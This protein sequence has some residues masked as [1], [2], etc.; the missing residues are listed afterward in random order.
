MEA[1]QVPPI[2][3]RLR[4]PLRAALRG[5]NALWPSDL[6]DEE[7]R[8][9]VEHGV[10]PLVY[11][12]QSLPN[13]RDAAIRA[14]AIEPL[15]AE[16]LRDVLRELAAR[17]IDVLITKGTALAYDVYAAPELRPR[18]DVDLLVAR[19][20][21]EAA[22]A[23]FRACGFTERLT[24]GDEH[25]VR[26][27]ALTRTD[28]H[29]VRHEYDLH[30]DVAN[31]P[32]FAS[33]LQFETVR[34]R[35]IA[36]PPLGEHARGLHHPDALLLACIH[37]VAHHH[38]SERLIWLVDIALLRDRMSP[39][40]HRDFWR[41]AAA[42]RVVGVCRRSIQLADEWL[43][44]AP[45]NRAEEFLSADELARDEASSAFLD[46]ELTYGGVMLANL[47]ALP[48]RERM[49]RLWQLAFP[50]AAFLRQT[51][52]ARGPLPWLY[53]RRGA[54]GVRRLF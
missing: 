29:G 30:W 7:V 16:D 10:A 51:Y 27:V 17:G 15:R 54:R 1:F 53:L 44:R 47:R 40:E 13:L 41:Q 25:G 24:S 12:V 18:G 48:W 5:Q 33:A 36:I 3:A 52:G 21:A 8:T 4:E 20:Q 43:S 34:A 28:A 37:R 49:Q 14:A 42:A 32:L 38:D 26:Q 22:I 19:D 31:T 35:A 11:A 2:P 23:A 6:E 39:D 46:R 9:L 50:P 45:R